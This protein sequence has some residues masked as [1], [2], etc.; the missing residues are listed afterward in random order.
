MQ[1]SFP[2]LYPRTK[3]PRQMISCVTYRRTSVLAYGR[4][5]ARPWD[6]TSHSV[7]PR[8]YDK[9]FALAALFQDLDN[10]NV[11]SL[12]T[13]ISTLSL[14]LQRLIDMDTDLESWYEE[15]LVR[16]TSPLYWPAQPSTTYT[17]F[18]RKIAD[19]GPRG[20][21]LLAYP[22]LTI[23]STTL[24]FWA[25]KILLSDEIANTSHI[26]LSTN[27]KARTDSQ[28]TDPA[29]SLKLTSMAQIAEKQHS[30]EKRMDLATEISRSVPYCLNSAM[31]L[32]GPERALFALRTAIAM[33]RR[34]PGPELEWCRKIY[35]RFNDRSGF[36]GAMQLH[37]YLYGPYQSRGIR[38]LPS[39][40][41]DGATPSTSEHT[42]ESRDEPMKDCLL[43]KGLRLLMGGQST[44]GL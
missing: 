5:L 44:A 21:P 6:E 19:S 9:G 2:F 26:I 42:I 11:A 3:Q 36:R 40:H 13:N 16:N 28:A 4:W 34:H 12:S 14:C 10:A 1:P 23:A 41:A 31:G 17:R 25:L 15:Y 22:N 43:T 18:E 39:S 32:L 27:H 33:F 8:V 29:A 20:L 24:T 38:D 7:H 37:P 30:K 35:S